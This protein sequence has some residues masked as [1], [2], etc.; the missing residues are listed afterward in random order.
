MFLQLSCIYNYKKVIEICKNTRFLKSRHSVQNKSWKKNNNKIHITY[1]L[2]EQ[3]KSCTSGTFFNFFCCAVSAFYPQKCMI[4]ISP[5]QNLD[6]INLSC[7]SWKCDIFDNKKIIK[8]MLPY[9][10][11]QLLI[12]V[13]W[14]Q[15]EKIK[16]SVF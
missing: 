12:D 5:S 7:L 2:Q 11:W 1:Y 4:K 15:H 3:R 9:V 13:C 14:Y 16:C 8:I 10:C 6:N